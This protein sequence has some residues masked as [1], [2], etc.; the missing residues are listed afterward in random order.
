[1]ITLKL[2][3]RDLNRAR[4]FY[5]ERGYSPVL[6]PDD[7]ILVAISTNARVIGAVRLCREFG[8]LV[9]R[10]MQVHPN[11]Q[12][13]GIGTKL[14]QRFKGLVLEE[15]CYCIP[16]AH[17]ESFY[18]Q[19]GFIGLDACDAPVFLEQRFDGLDNK[20]NYMVMKRTV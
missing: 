10:G 4:R 13:K 8:V 14:L 2:L 1:M 7:R 5:V 20:K 19:I 18:N 17:L 11:Y 9:L 12:R 3:E 6:Y 16:Y 15:D